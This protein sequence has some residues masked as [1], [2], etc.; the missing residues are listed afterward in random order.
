MRESPIITLIKM[1]WWI[2]LLIGLGM[3]AFGALLK[4]DNIPG[5]SPGKFAIGQ[6]V[7][8]FSVFFLAFSAI[9]FLAA[10]YREFFGQ[11]TRQ[12]EAAPPLSKNITPA[13]TLPPPP[14]KKKYSER[15]FMPPALRAELDAK[16]PPAGRE[17]PARHL[18]A[19]TLNGGD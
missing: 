15:D 1:P 13:P 5:A 11:W 12:P 16:E 17:K 2:N 8:F 6:S 19:R 7:Q 9:S 4:M 10:F 3:L 18:P 14:K